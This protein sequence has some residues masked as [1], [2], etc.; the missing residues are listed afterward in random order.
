MKKDYTHLVL[1]IDKSGSMASL[2]DA[3]I[4]GV[5]SLV[6]DQKKLPGTLTTSLYTFDGVVREVSLFET[7]T[8]MNYCPSGST[9]LLDAVMQAINKEGERL[10]AKAEQDRPDK[11]VVVIVTDGEENASR[12]AKI[13]EVKNLVAMQQDIY[14]WQFVFL[15]ANIDAFATGASLSF[16][17]M[18]TRNFVASAEGLKAAYSCTSSSLGSY[19]SGATD[20][21][22]LTVDPTK[23]NP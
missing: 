13:E 17:P 1:V 6:A 16:S 20:A 21:V 4:E 22:N 14:K 10:A 23:T 19:R 15:G 5:N 9:A 7:L 3:T 2:Q 8:K 11:V 12:T 18:S